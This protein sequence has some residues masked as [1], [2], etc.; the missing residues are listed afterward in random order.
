MYGNPNNKHNGN[1]FVRADETSSSRRR[2]PRF[3]LYQLRSEHSIIMF[4][5]AIVMIVLLVQ[6]QA[7]AITGTYVPVQKGTAGHCAGGGFPGETV[8]WELTTP[9][10]TVTTG[11]TTVNEYGDYRFDIPKG[12]PSGTKIKWWDEEDTITDTVAYVADPPGMK[13]KVHHVLLAGSFVTVNGM[14]LPL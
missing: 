11:S 13:C 14:D 3:W 12:T 4:L 9:G 5:L 2:R 6:H 7:N 1:G 10:G 8:W